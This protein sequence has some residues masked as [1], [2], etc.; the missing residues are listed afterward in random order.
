MCEDCLSISQNLD[1]PHFSVTVHVT[2]WPIL[3]VLIFVNGQL[4]DYEICCIRLSQLASAFEKPDVGMSKHNLLDGVLIEK[5][6]TLDDIL[7][8]VLNKLPEM[9]RNDHVSFLCIDSIGGLARNE[10]DV[11]QKVQIFER[12]AV[13][14]KLSQSLKWLADTF[15]VCVVVVNQ[16]GNACCRRWKVVYFV[17]TTHWLQYQYFHVEVE[18]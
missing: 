18:V 12:T 14:F 17:I 3:R 4:W 16:V 6:H 9:C 2:A 1:Y 15:G 5:C 8:T 13:L 7:D 10:F 11:S